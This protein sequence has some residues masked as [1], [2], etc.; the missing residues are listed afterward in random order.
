M[1][2]QKGVDMMGAITLMQAIGNAFG[3]AIGKLKIVS[4]EA[5]YQV[6]QKMVE[7]SRLYMTCECG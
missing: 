6:T 5:H 2:I 1:R 3:N 4:A 7:V